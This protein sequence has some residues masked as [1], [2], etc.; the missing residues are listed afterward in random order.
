M[1]SFK[2]TTPSRRNTILTPYKE[3]LSGDQEAKPKNLVKGEKRA[4]GRNNAGRIT[5]RHR[6][7]GNKKL[8]RVVDFKFDKK[9]VPGKIE[10]VQ[11]DPLRTGFVAL[12]CYADGERR[13]VLAPKKMKAGDTIITSEKAP[14]AV[15]NR[16]PLKNIPIGTQIYNV[17]LQPN[18]GAKIARSA[19]NFVELIANDNGQAFLKMPSSEVRK[20]SENAWACVGLVSNDQNKLRN[21]GKA[22]RNRWKGIRPTVRGTAMNPVDHPHGGGE[23]RQGR[24]LRRAKT[25]WGKPSGKGQKT[26]SPK[27][28]SNVFVVTR[29]VVGGK[30]K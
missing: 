23:G 11:Y 19:G 26:R 4:M 22:G 8:L 16:L 15:G 21:E 6:G 29:R 24:G 2:P 9:D 5:M 30:K 10:A 27:K 14:I 25:M 7:G 12:V 28:Y 1:K 13:Y 3:L 17:E 20:V 18:G